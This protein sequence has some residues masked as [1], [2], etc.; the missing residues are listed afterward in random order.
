[1]AKPKKVND[2]DDLQFKKEIGNRF[3]QFRKT[4][5][6][7]RD[8]LA[9]ELNVRQTIFANIEKGL[10]SPGIP[11]LFYFSKIYHLNCN[12][13]LSGNGSM[14]EQK[15]TMPDKTAAVSTI[16]CHIPLGDARYKRYQELL[17]YMQMPEVEQIILAR[18]QELKHIAVDQV[19][20]LK[21]RK[22]ENAGKVTGWKVKRER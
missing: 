12:W 9:E 4:I 13:L 20:E 22:C 3:K 17:Y 6:K 21:K 5:A 14:F 16:G 19:E 8:Q 1:M 10:T 2:N 7:T 18:L 11:Y 15:E